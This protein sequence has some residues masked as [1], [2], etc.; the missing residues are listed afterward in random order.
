MSD[1]EAGKYCYKVIKEVEFALNNTVNKST[2][3]TPSMLLFGVSQRGKVIDDM[4]AYV[5]NTVTDD[6][7][8]DFKEIREQAA[9]KIFKA[10]EYNKKY[11][12]QKRRK[13]NEY[14]QEFKGPY[15]V[16]RRLRQDRYVIVHPEGLQNS[17]KPYQGVWE[18]N[19]MRPWK[20]TTLTGD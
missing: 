4:K 18:A 12:D 14:D 10:Q 19:N 1:D 8:C 17:Q 20:D 3:Q 11:V 6:I 15:V 2:G 13:V 7:P 16:K 5:E 9:E